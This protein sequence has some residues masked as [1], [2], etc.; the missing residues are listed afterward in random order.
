MKHTLTYKI[1]I[2]LLLIGIPLL[3]GT[4]CIDEYNPVVDRYENLL[5]VEGSITNI[6][7][8]YRVKLS[9]SSPVNTPERTPFSGCNLRIESREGE[10]EILNETA[11]GTYQS[12]ND[13]FLGK[14][15]SFYRLLI[16]SPDGEQYAS[17]FE[18]LKEAVSIDSIYT[19]VVYR[20]VPGYVDDVA[21]LQFYVNTA[22][23]AL[24]T[25]YYLWKMEKTYQYQSDFFIRF[26]FDGKLALFPKPDSFYNCWTTRPVNEI[27][28]NS[29]LRLTQSQLQGMPLHYVSTLNRELSV[30][31]SLYMEQYTLTE[32]AFLYW[33]R[34]QEQNIEEGALYTQQP[35]Q[36]R[37]NV[38]NL[39]NDDEPVLGYFMVA[40]VDHRR[41]FVDRPPL[42]FN[43]SK[44]ELGEGD[45]DAFGFIGW[46]DP[47][48]WPLY[49][50]TNANNRRALPNQACLDCRLKGGSLEKPAF[51]ID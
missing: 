17:A 33:S 28:T 36:I 25:N 32:K 22:P 34:L 44:C 24:D 30:K 50:T 5:A 23:A 35:F 47:R 45:Y 46:T 37:G 10:T 15:G 27:F 7:G 12:S 43:Y 18:Q 26:V 8:P 3:T 40:G 4:A 13:G 20:K 1:R 6:P 42:V 51:W 38:H 29:T 39:N 19:E 48:V 16:T 49:V 9:L 31:Y 21:G 14:T 11:P 2:V 41:I